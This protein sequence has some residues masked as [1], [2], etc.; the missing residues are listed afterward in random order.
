METRTYR[1]QMRAP[2]HVGEQG[3]GSEATLAHLP[4]DSLFSALVVNWRTLPELEPWLPALID[5]VGPPPLLLT[6]AFPYAGEIRL[7]P[8]PALPFSPLQSGQGM[9]E[10]KKAR[11]VSMALFEQ[12]VAGVDQAAL[13]DLWKNAELVQ[14]GAVWLTQADAEAAPPHLQ[15][16]ATGERLIWRSDVVPRVTLD[17]RTNAS[18]IYHIGRTYFADKCGLWFAAR[19]EAIWLDRLEQ[20]LEVMADAGVGGLRSIGNGQFALQKEGAAPAWL[21]AP[22]GSAINHGSYVVLLSRT[23]PSQAE[24][25]LLRANLANYQLTLV[26]GFSGT[27]GMNP[28]VR[29]QVRLL[30]EGSVIGAPTGETMGHLVKV[31]PES[32]PWLEHEIYRCGYGFAIPIVL[33]AVEVQS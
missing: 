30:V 22:T 23:A 8:K 32:T 28:L 10:V 1:L 29:R 9:K 6:S 16:N 12:M 3:I 4:N 21:S 20:V 7:L 18:Q 25:A 14:E 11:W 26:G 24:M 31:T 17:R 33:E 15:R 27:P 2:L 19:G 5:P 13:A